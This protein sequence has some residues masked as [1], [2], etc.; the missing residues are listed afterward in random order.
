MAMAAQFV[1]SWTQFMGCG[2]NGGTVTNLVIAANGSGTCQ[3]NQQAGASRGTNETGP[4]VQGTWTNAVGEYGPTVTFKPGDGGAEETIHFETGGRYGFRAVP[5]PARRAAMIH[6]S[7][8]RQPQ[9]SA[10]R[11]DEGKRGDEDAAAG[12]RPARPRRMGMIHHLSARPPQFSAPRRDEKCP[13]NH[14]LRRGVATDG[15]WCDLCGAEQQRGA[16]LFGCHAQ[17]RSGEC[18][19]DLC[20]RCVDAGTRRTGGA[21]ENWKAGFQGE[22]G[23]AFRKIKVTVNQLDDADEEVTVEWVG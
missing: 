22:W 9:F 11:R 4:A 13:K 18:D 3:R 23:D 15:M 6:H 12:P 16:Q 21:R 17:S 7:S 2:T 20:R 14:T 1:G 19:Y 5:R 8:A 10:P